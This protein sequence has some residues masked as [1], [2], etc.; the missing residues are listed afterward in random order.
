MCVGWVD[1]DFTKD[2][3]CELLV[4]KGESGPVLFV[5]ALQCVGT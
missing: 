4:G 5:C 3:E 1:S 2:I